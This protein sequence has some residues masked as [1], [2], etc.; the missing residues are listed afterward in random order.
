MW[1][2]NAKYWWTG[3]ESNYYLNRHFKP[4]NKYKK[5][6]FQLDQTVRI[7]FSANN[8][9]YHPA[10]EVLSTGKIVVLC[11]HIGAQHNQH[12]QRDTVP[13]AGLLWS[14]GVSQWPA[15]TNTRWI[16]SALGASQYRHSFSHSSLRGWRLT[17]LIPDN[18]KW[19]KLKENIIWH[20]LYTPPAKKNQT[21]LL[22]FINIRR[23][24]TNI[25]M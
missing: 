16:S 14:G 10:R 3:P 2:Y 15:I 11:T 25:I 5:G 17:S 7:V 18:K 22:I 21:V 4:C 1:G 19:V 9:F 24:R 23:P 13:T 8:E 6:Q 12:E 20:R